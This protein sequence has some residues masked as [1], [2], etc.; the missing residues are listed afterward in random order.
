MKYFLL[1]SFALLEINLFGQSVPNGSFELGNVTIYEEPTGFSTGNWRDIDRFAAPS[2][3]K[4]TGMSGSAARIQT[5]VAGNADVSESYMIGAPNPCDDPQN[6]HGGIPFNQKATS[7]VGYYRYNLPGSDTA[8]AIVVFSKNGVQVSMDLFKIRGTGSQ[9]TFTTFS[10]PLSLSVVPDSVIIAFASTNKIGNMGA[11]N[12]GYIE[13]DNLSFAGT[14]IAIPNGDFE[15]W[16]SA[17]YNQITNWDSWGD[18]V[19]RS[20]EKVDGVFG[21][22][23]KTTQGECSG[24]NPHTSGITSGNDNE[25]SGPSGGRPYTKMNDTLAGYYKYTPVGNDSAVISISLTKN[26][27]P[28]AGMIKYLTAANTFTWFQIPFSSGTAP[29]TIRVDIMSSKWN[30][31]Q[32]NVGSTLI[33]DLV[34]LRSEPVG[35]RNRSL[36]NE[37]RLHPNPVKDHLD[38]TFGNMSRLK[39]VSVIN[40]L[41]QTIA[42][43]HTEEINLT[44]NTTDLAPG[45]Y[46]VQVNAGQESGVRRFVK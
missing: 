32:A 14:T 10:F 40:S 24:G 41:G 39:T 38:L 42:T 17:N 15:N 4:V 23:I 9:S 2:V 20:T 30:I 18:G 16:T 22:Q 34:H 8:I 6:W 5:M 35:I 19:T 43:Y 13:I 28:V 3:T 29:D 25:Q 46:F 31:T 37:L 1:L 36:T 33:V 12:G 27:T 45:V 44:V 11:Q 7:L 21:L 26:G